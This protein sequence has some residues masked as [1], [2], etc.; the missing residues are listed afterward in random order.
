MS[1]CN[2]QYLENTGGHPHLDRKFQECLITLLKSP[3]V[4]GGF[5][6]YTLCHTNR[7]S[8]RDMNRQSETVKSLKKI[9]AMEERPQ[10][11]QTKELTPEG[12]GRKL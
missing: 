9:S 11:Q 6:I 4:G 1:P 8:N 3:E 12:N 2:L 5:R 10:M 7:F